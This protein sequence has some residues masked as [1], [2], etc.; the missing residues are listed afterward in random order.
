MAADDPIVRPEQA[1]ADWLLR[2]QGTTVHE[3]VTDADVS[4][5]L[6]KEHVEIRAARDAGDER[7]IDPLGLGEVEP[8]EMRVV[9]KVALDAPSLA[10]HL[11]PFAAGV[12]PQTDVLELERAVAVLG[13]LV[14]GHDKPFLFQRVERLRTVGRHREGAGIDG[15]QQALD[16]ARLELEPRHLLR[17]RRLGRF[18]VILIGPRG[19]VGEEKQDAFGT[20]F[21]ARIARR[22]NGQREYSLVEPVEVD[23][24]VG[25]PLGLGRRRVLRGLLRGLGGFRRG[26][27]LVALRTDRRRF[28]V[29]QH[30]DVHGAAHR[31]TEAAHIQPASPETAVSA[32]DEIEVLAVA[33]EAGRNRVA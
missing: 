6:F 28:V 17:R 24:H 11:L 12:D 19:A 18:Q 20:G 10:V 33:I 29:L 25:D 9:Q 4:G 8:V 2:R 1:N 14:G 15:L 31:A 30:G 3:G 16:L 27:F 32:G 21:E 23:A 26:R 7:R 13:L 5:H 22:C